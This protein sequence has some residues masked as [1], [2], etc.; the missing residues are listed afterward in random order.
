MPIL[1]VAQLLPLKLPNLNQENRPLLNVRCDFIVN[2]IA[3][4]ESVL[5]GIAI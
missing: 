5:D 3:L 1:A 4:A 2:P